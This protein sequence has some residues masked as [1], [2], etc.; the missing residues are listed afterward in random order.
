[1]LDVIFEPKSEAA[2]LSCMCHAPAE[3]QKEMVGML[4]EDHFYLHE[5]KLIYQ[6]I[7]RAVGSGHHADW[8]SVLNDITTSNQLDIVGGN[9]KI[10]EIAT[11][12]PSHKNWR[13]YWPKL[14]EARYRRALEVLAEDMKQKARDREMKLGELKNWSETAVL[15]TDHMIDDCEKLGVSNA[16]KES[17]ED[18]EAAMSGKPNIGLRTGLAKLDSLIINGMRGGD[19]VVI[20]ARP[21]VGKTAAA[22]QIAMNAALDAK[23]RVLFF[24]LEMQSKALIS[25]MICS[26]AFVPK[27]NILTGMVSKEDRMRLGTASNEIETSG[28]LIDDRSALSIGHIKAVSRRVHQR[29]PLDLVLI[30]YLQ[31]AK[32]ESKRS[33]DNRV[34]EVEEISNGVKEL[35]KTLNIPVVVLAQLNRDPEKRST[36][37]QLSDLKGSGAVEQDADIVIMLHTD[38]DDAANFSQTPTVEFI[39]CKQRDGEQGVALYTFNKAI[40]RFE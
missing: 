23:K 36:R 20:A 31:L 7:L 6:A 10:A 12:C 17:L 39:V 33:K 14:E 2:M 9:A 29:E 30:D 34:C 21:S 26:R 5:H 25:R 35:A 15:K 27:K 4:K 37:P 18:M 28:L 32:G 22:L 40:T 19:M 11:F 16:V 38:Q 13:R 1:M 24:S 8:V 3:I